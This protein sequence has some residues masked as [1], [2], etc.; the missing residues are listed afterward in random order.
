MTTKNILK[1]TVL[2]LLLFFIA[3]AG[4]TQDE[5]Q[6]RFRFGLKATGNFGW[7]K[8]NSK[9]I[10]NGGAKTGYS[11]G[12]MG[13]YSFTKNYALAT[14]F[15]I[16]DIRANLKFANTM[17][18]T[19]D[20]NGDSI[21]TSFPN[22][23]IDYKIKYIQIPV[24]IKFKTKEIG[25]VTYWAQ[26]GIAPSFLASAKADYQN[27]Q[28]ADEYAKM[29]VNDKENDKYHMAQV[30]DGEVFND[31]VF[32]VRVPLVVGAGIEYNLAGNTSLYTGLRFDNGFTNTFIKDSQTKANLNYVSLNVG[33]FF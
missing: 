25:L 11:W 13:D 20:I 22:T 32:F 31:K 3:T 8:P 15:L 19:N 21:F 30:K 2:F 12:L 5:P 29:A 24:S 10:E 4:F 23:S 16:T 27:V 6:D 17:R 7:F 28:P 9:N 1:Q 14:E 18:E 33:L 26:F